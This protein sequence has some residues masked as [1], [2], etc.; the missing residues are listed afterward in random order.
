M[1]WPVLVIG[2]LS[3]VLILAGLVPPYFEL[4]KRHGQVVGMSMLIQQISSVLSLIIIGMRFLT[5]DIAGAAF[6][7]LALGK[8]S[9]HMHLASYSN[10]YKL[11]KTHLMFWE[12]FCI[13]SCKSSFDT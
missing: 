2:I 11:C 6:S 9:C 7:L 1:E 4:A 8:L 10:T 3:T 12:V 13:S 5:I